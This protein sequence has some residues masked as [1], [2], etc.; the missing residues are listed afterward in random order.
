MFVES[1]I[2]LK[3]AMNDLLERTLRVLPLKKR[4]GTYSTS[5]VFNK[6]KKYLRWSRSLLKQATKPVLK[7]CL[8]IY[9]ENYDEAIEDTIK[10]IKAL[11]ANE[12]SEA[13]IF[14]TAVMTCPN[15]CEESFTELSVRISPIKS[16]SENLIDFVD[17][18]LS[19]LNQFWNL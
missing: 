16:K 17:L 18:I 5:T 9:E 3:Y 1:L 11:D 10:S 13:R 19:L 7:E 8:H 2:T 4:F 15:T 6:G 12:F 14:A